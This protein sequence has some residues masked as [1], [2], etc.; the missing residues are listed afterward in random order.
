MMESEQAYELEIDPADFQ[1]RL[2]QGERLLISFGATW[3]GPCKQ[4][5]PTLSKLGAALAG[6]IRVGRIETD[7]HPELGTRFQIRAYPT[8]LLFDAGL[9]RGRV[10]GLQSAS[11]LK[12]WIEKLLPPDQPLEGLSMT[13]PDWGAFYGNECLRK[14][15]VDELLR[16]AM[17]GKVIQRMF[18]TW[19]GDS[20]TPSAALVKHD[21]PAVF[22]RVS[23]MPF[24]F[25]VV[26]ELDA[27]EGSES[28]G[29]IFAALPSG[30]DLSEIFPHLLL[31]WLADERECWAA[32]LADS[33]L[34]GLRLRWLELMR[35]RLAGQ[36]VQAEDWTQLRQAL[37][38]WTDAHREHELGWHLGSFLQNLSPPPAL[39]APAS[40]LLPL[41]RRVQLLRYY[42]A[43]LQAGATPDI[44]KLDDRVHQWFSSRWSIEAYQALSTTE[45]AAVHAQMRSDLKLE[46]DAKAVVDELAK[47]TRRAMLARFRSRLMSLLQTCP[48]I[49]N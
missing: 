8:L 42:L 19:D 48:R 40:V 5:Q 14:S 32:Q 4:M 2:A 37:Q 27:E 12:S 28:L 10:T 17:E 38:P 23:G 47:A 18:P 43:M 33:A 49:A 35:K 9:E 36:A 20:G 29:E 3:C 6:Q 44:L 13:R 46:L 11:Q 15:L 34:D 1:Q 24:S 22:E 25:A 26:L 21:N 16:L 7:L 45:Q 30:A 41:Q 39:D 31:H